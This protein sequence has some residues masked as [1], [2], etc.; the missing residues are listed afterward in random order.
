MSCDGWIS[1]SNGIRDLLTNVWVDT[2]AEVRDELRRC[3]GGHP[4]AVR[5]QASDRR[6]EE[7]TFGHAKLVRSMVLLPTRDSMAEGVN[8]R[9]AKSCL[10]SLFRVADGAFDAAIPL[11]GLGTSDGQAF[12]GSPAGTDEDPE[13]VAYGF[14]KT[15]LYVP[16]GCSVLVVGP[17]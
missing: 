3:Q 1:N 17:S 16:P 4:V 9:Y 12:F 6:R 7:E 2:S 13:A 11:L 15:W 10:S 14:T 5:R 8:L